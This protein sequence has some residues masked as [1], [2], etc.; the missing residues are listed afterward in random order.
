[1]ATPGSVLFTVSW[2]ILTLGFG[3]YAAN[4]ANYGATY[5]SLSAIV[6]ALTWVYLSSYILLL[7]AEL[8]SEL[9]HQTAHDTTTGPEM[10]LGE[11]G[12]W[13]ADHVAGDKL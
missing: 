13:V 6:A 4:F 2:I 9:E 1:M 7:G 5:G 12:A 10:P 8:N 11:R 3:F